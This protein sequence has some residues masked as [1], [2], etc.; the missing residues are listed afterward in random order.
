M[1]TTI[2][3]TP[4]GYI[5]PGMT[6]PSHYMNHC[7]RIIDEVQWQSPKS[8]QAIFLC[9]MSLKI[10][11]SKFGYTS[12]QFNVFLFMFVSYIF[13]S[14]KTLAFLYYTSN[15]FIMRL[16]LIL[17]KLHTLKYIKVLGFKRE[18]PQNIENRKWIWSTVM[19]YV[20]C[21]KVNVRVYDPDTAIISPPAAAS[22]QCFSLN[23]KVIHKAQGGST[24]TVHLSTDT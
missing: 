24:T 20:H 9:I 4:Y 18:I 5:E 19:Y 21:T 17:R 12:S 10:V 11:F 6:A 7:W 2:P 22:K 23:A 8:A 1:L 14:G 3:I 15:D 16:W 13:K